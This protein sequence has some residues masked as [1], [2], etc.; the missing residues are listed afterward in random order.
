MRHLRAIARAGALIVWTLAMYAA[1]VLGLLLLIAVRAGADRWRGL[2]FH[3]WARVSA[4]ILAVKVAVRGTPPEPPFLLVSNHLSYVD[5]VVYASLIK[6]VFVARA[7]VASWPVI[8]LLCRGVKTIFIDRGNRKDAVRVNGL[9]DRAIEDGRGVVLFA[10]GTSTKGDRV[11]PFKSSLLEQAAR[12][13]LAVSY[14]S[15]TYRTMEGEPPA[16]LSVCWWGEM[17]FVKHVIGLLYLTDIHATLVFGLEPIRAN[18]RKVLATRLWG[19][20]SEQFVT[21]VGSDSED[22]ELL[23][24]SVA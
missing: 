21:V 2:V 23:S 15:V 16:H 20:V 11:L 13:S 18:N 4:G 22:A 14:A 7:D 19:A 8:G 12:A 24:A 1:L 10:E 5:V 3:I 6:C 17:T 9:I